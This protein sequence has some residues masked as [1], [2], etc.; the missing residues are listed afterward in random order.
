MVLLSFSCAAT[1]CEVKC[2]LASVGSGCHSSSH[3][4]MQRSQV[5]AAQM[6]GMQS[7]VTNETSASSAGPAVVSAS[8][9][10]IRH[11]CVEQPVSLNNDNVVTVHAAVT[12]EAVILIAA[13][14]MPAAPSE[15]ISGRGSR[16][17]LTTSPVSLHTTVRV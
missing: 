7:Q 3:A 17:V 15:W 10:C 13:L 5:M 4:S 9:P 12:Y 1:A 8:T 2:N 11:V 14:T 16:H 6:A